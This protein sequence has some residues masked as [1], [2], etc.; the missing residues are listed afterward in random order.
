MIIQCGDILWIWNSFKDFL[1]S[2]N[3]GSLD[4]QFI[5]PAL[6]AVLAWFINESRKRVTD[7][8]QRKEESYK[9]LL[10][11]LDGFYVN[12]ENAERKIEEFLNQLTIAWLYC[13]DEIIQKG[14]TF[15]DTVHTDEVA[16]DK[17]KEDALGDFVSSIRT[18]L[19]SRKLVKKSKLTKKN[20][21]ILSVNYHSK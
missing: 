10:R 16:A 7:Q 4:W 12:A 3:L 5:L 15:L 14:Y 17:N 9:E 11:S 8:Y 18:D 20:F 21:K 19:L 6:G 13:P 2:L 1:G